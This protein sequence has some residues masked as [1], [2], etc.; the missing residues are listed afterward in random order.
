[1]GSIEQQLLLCS[2][3]MCKWWQLRWL[4]CHACK[5]VLQHCVASC[6]VFMFTAGVA[7]NFLGVVVYCLGGALV[8][9]GTGSMGVAFVGF[10]CTLADVNCVWK[11]VLERIS[12]VDGQSLLTMCLCSTARVHWHV[13]VGAALQTVLRYAY[14]SAT[15][16]A[17]KLAWHIIWHLHHTIT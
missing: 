7:C 9:T 14:A 13:V 5:R 2:G 17:G 12:S 16:P 15:H 1:M 4:V 10:I 11:T 3:R 6:P 8:G